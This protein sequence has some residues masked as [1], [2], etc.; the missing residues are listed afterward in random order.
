MDSPGCNNADSD[1]YMRMPPNPP[2]V[3]L[4]VEIPPELCEEEDVIL[5]LALTVIDNWLLHLDG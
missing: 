2:L 4:K 5:E 1:W 3:Y